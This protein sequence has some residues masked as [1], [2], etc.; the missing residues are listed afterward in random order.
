MAGQILC[1]QWPAIQCIWEI[2]CSKDKVFPS[3]SHLPGK[4]HYSLIVHFG[5][6]TF[7]GGKCLMS[8]KHSNTNFQYNFTVFNLYVCMYVCIILSNNSGKDMARIKH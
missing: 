2:F 1:M 8:V 5:F 7:F 4:I 3:C 6:G